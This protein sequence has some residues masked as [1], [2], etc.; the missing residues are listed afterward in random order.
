MTW[1]GSLQ[2]RRQLAFDAGQFRKV[3]DI[4]KMVQGART[5]FQRARETACG[6]EMVTDCSMPRSACMLGG[7]CRDIFVRIKVALP[8]HRRRPGDRYRFR[9]GVH[10]IRQGLINGRTCDYCASRGEYLNGLL[11]ANIWGS[12][13]DPRI[14]FFPANGMLDSV[15]TNQGGDAL[16]AVENAV[17]PGFTA[18]GRTAPSQLLPRGSD[19]RARFVARAADAE[20]YEKW[21][22]VSGFLMADPASCDAKVIIPSPTRSS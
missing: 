5:W 14:R 8:G 19:I 15:R 13:Y 21:S 18:R 1:A 3:R 20:C 16:R 10:R 2:S 22:D 12:V 11:L 6:D 9:R 4:I 7:D 17:I